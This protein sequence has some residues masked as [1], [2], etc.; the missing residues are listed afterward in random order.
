MKPTEAEA[1]L[2]QAGID[3]MRRAETL[4]IDEWKVLCEKVG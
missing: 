2:T 3:P 1:L 4:S